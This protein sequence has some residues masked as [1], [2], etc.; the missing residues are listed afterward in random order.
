M[1]GAGGSKLF[2]GFNQ[3]CCVTLQPLARWPQ[4]SGVVGLTAEP[5]GRD[6][7]QQSEGNAE[8][9]DEQVADRQ[10]TD[11]DVRCRLH[12][13]L[14]DDDVDHQAVARQ[15]QDEDDRVHDDKGGLGAV[16][17]LGHVDQRL[18]LV[19]VDKFLAAQV[20]EAQ[21]LLKLLRGDLRALLARVG[22]RFRC[23]PVRES[24]IKSRSRVP[25]VWLGAF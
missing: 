12:G 14:L 13:A 4:W 11:E 24:W 25:R 18:Q 20:V 2:P 21:H 19:G 23:H 5:L 22:G 15:S 10:R 3:S 8:E 9:S 6:V 1:K 16:R 7:L 17:Q